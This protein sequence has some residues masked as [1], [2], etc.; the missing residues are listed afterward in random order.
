MADT[1]ATKPRSTVRRP[2]PVPA[3][4][5]AAAHAKVMRWLSKA[6]TGEVM[7]AS[8]KAGVYKSDGSLTEHYKK[9]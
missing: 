5:N 4:A 9:R 1:T 6:S 3:H 8:V 2:S 7:K